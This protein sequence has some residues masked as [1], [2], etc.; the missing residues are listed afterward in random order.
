MYQVEQAVSAIKAICPNTKPLIGIVLGSGLGSLIDEI[1]DKVVIPY[2]KLPGFPKPSVEGHEGNLIIGKLSGIEVA[3]L[4]GR[5]H[6]YEH[7]NHEPVKQYVRTLKVLGCKYFLATNASG[8]LREDFIPGDLVLV[9]DHINMQ[10]TNPLI[11]PNDDEFGPR[12]PPLDNAYDH[13]V[14][15]SLAQKAAQIDINL[16]EGIYIS[17]IGPTYET[18]AEIRAFRLM[19]ADLVGMSTVPEVIV[20]NHC[21]MKVAVIATITNMATGLTKTSHSHEAVVATANQASKKLKQ[22]VK[23]F[24]ADLVKGH[25]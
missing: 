8:S 11:G 1:Q 10:G 23:N 9:T 12:F 22:L 2:S 21:G 16:H 4:Q 15:Q 7:G 6:T 19:G 5:S 25:K 17:V 3:C 14:R 20:A 13:D 18:A 24:V